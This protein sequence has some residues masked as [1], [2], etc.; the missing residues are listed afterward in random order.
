MVQSTSAFFANKVNNNSNKDSS[1]RTRVT[2][3]STIEEWNGPVFFI[4]LT[5]RYI[6]QATIRHAFPVPAR[7]SV[8]HCIVVVDEVSSARFFNRQDVRLA[9]RMN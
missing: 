2:H 8:A 3:L 9:K 7:S 6:K 1:I 5:N 4:Y